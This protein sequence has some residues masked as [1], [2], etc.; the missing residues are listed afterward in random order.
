MS[1]PQSTHL[2]GHLSDLALDRLLAGELDG[3]AGEGV[4]AH[5]AQCAACEARRVE[6]TREAEAFPQSVWIAGEAAKVKK[7]LDA[8]PARRFAPLAG[9]TAFAAAASV[10]AVA[11]LAGPRVDDATQTKGGAV[12]LELYARLADGRV[13]KLEEGALLGAGDAIRF[14]VT[15]DRAG[16]LSIVGVDGAGTVSTYLQTS[17][18]QAVRGELLEGSVVLDDA[19]IAERFFAILCDN[20]VAPSLPSVGG[21][22]RRTTALGT[23]CREGHFLVRKKSR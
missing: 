16:S 6:L 7:Q 11:F 1:D 3:A 8:G 20:G 9:V 14:Q 13:E 12:G 15:T 18:P 2:S 10:A 5:L 22:P 23:G 19:P 17:L 4:R 21:D